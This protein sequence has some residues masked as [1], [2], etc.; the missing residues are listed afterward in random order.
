M[1][2]KG[3]VLLLLGLI[4]RLTELSVSGCLH[5]LMTT[6]QEL[7]ASVAA[8]LDPAI[9]YETRL[10]SNGYRTLNSIKQVGNAETLQRDCELLPGDARIIWQAAVGIAGRCF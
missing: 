8:D 3:L 10:R 2:V 4:S 7:L 6:L 9:D 5:R 1:S